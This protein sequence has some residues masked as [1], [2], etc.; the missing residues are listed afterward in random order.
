MRFEDACIP[1]KLSMADYSEQGPREANED[2]VMLTGYTVT[3]GF[4][5][6]LA[7]VADGLGGLSNGEVASRCAVETI[8]RHLV[9]YRNPDEDAL[10]DAI[11]EAS[12]KVYEAQT[13]AD[14]R[15]TVAALWVDRFRAYAAHVGDT[16]IYQF[17]DGKIIYQSTDHSVAQMA[18]DIGKLAQ[19]DIR[20]SKDRNRLIR[21]LGGEEPP[22]VDLEEL[23]IQPGDRFLLCSDGFWEPV[24][25]EDMVAAMKTG[26]TAETWLDAMRQNL[27]RPGKE[28]HDNNSAIA[29]IME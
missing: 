4:S 2:A 21:T 25:E 12:R 22:R 11:Q 7:V 26:D 29:L 6:V 16:R 1:V 23:E 15:T 8:Q 28:P 17:R 9:C 19:S 24:T 10:Y 5:C 18:V 14:M 27:A 13:G 20:Q 3:G